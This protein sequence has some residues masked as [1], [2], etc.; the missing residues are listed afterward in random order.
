MRP[1]ALC[2]HQDA[3][4]FSNGVSSPKHTTQNMEITYLSKREIPRFAVDDVK[5]GQ[6]L[7][8]VISLLTKNN[9][10]TYRP[11]MMIRYRF[12]SILVY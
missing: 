6:C 8:E 1:D 5:R 4:L 2:E 7:E 10:C 9:R 11:L 12:L 3:L